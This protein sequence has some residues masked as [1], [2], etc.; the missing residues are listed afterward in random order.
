M[1]RVVSLWLPFW[2]ID[3]LRREKQKGQS[4]NGQ[5]P[6]TATSR[7]PGNPRPFA[8]TARGPKG[9]LLH[10]VD[11]GDAAAMSTG[12]RV[13]PQWA[14]DATGSITDIACFVP[15]DGKDAS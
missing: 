3:L 9:P 11:T 7:G 15:A 1:K 13:T 10:A 6:K 5:R 12:M 2:P 4:Q 8:L 14:D